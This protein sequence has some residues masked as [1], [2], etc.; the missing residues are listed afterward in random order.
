M[1][2]S[3]QSCQAKYT[4]ADEKVLGKIVK[5]RCKK[6]GATIVINGNEAQ[7]SS[8]D[9]GGEQVFDYTAS[10]GTEQ[11]TVNVTDGDQRTLTAQEIV[12]EYRANVINDETFCWKDGMGDWLPLREIGALHAACAEG[13]R[14]SLSPDI[15]MSGYGGTHDPMGSLATRPNDVA[16]ANIGALF[17]GSGATDDASPSHGGTNGNGTKNG[18]FGDASPVP[19]VAARR[20]GGRGGG[21]ADLF[22]GVAQAGGEEDVM[23][24][25]P[26]GP[27]QP[28]GGDPGKLTGQRN[29]NSVLFS[30]SALTEKGEKEA[31]AVP[32]GDGSGLIDIRA[33]SQNITS[34]KPSGSA[35]VDDIMNLGGGGAFSAA[36]AAPILAPP[37]MG[38]SDASIG[39]VEGGGKK[40]MLLF[41][42]IGA[43]VFVCMLGTI[44]M[45]MARKPET[46]TA[47]PVMNSPAMG[48]ASPAPGGDTP[49]ATAAL[50]MN[51]TP[52][53]A[54]AAVKDPVAAPGTGAAQAKA[55][56]P[57]VGGGG[58]G[59]GGAARNNNSAPVAP[60]DPTPA[61]AP[62][63]PKAPASL[64]DEL[65]KVA[66]GGGGGAPAT[67]APVSN[68][69]FDRGSAS[70]ALGA[71]NVA[72]CKKGDGPTGSGHVTVTFAPNG[73]VVSAVV[74]QPPFAGTA[75]GG[76]V[77][78]KFRSA[79]VPA[80]SGNP[81]KVGKSFSIN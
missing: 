71:I 19:P 56:S 30:L 48:S 18:G 58:G 81:I 68:V 10:A 36:L 65:Q 54:S 37:P 13:P 62:A 5:I 41:G 26:V 49:P 44:I 28:H 51:D 7:A 70:G 15:P 79:H 24:S 16:S 32:Q 31:S 43:V 78:G 12:A 8:S 3:C 14:P 52:P 57:K 67:A 20:Q 66:G 73:S 61:P 77:A 75:V 9:S 21:G 22:G 6:C 23:T 42:G 74:D 29:E 55:A 53:A 4:I 35:H 72:A 17:A 11:W 63:A 25:A 39:N 38:A 27:P 69:P 46:A 33:L 2:I 34:S 45:L 50:A 80:F 47:V 40:K 64:A 60:P 59:G 1:K 76:C